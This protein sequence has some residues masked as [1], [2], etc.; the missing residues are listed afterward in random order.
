ME[1]R[2]VDPRDQ[3]WELSDPVY[4]VYFHDE[5]GTS[6]EYEL[7]GAASIADVLAWA[8]ATRGD[9]TFVVYACVPQDGLGLVRL[10]GSDPNE[11][12]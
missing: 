1:T 8:G 12:T 3:T 5:H 10:H 9:R 11:A 7:S 6:D 2:S 4:R